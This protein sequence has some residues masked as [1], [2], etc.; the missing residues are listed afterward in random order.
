VPVTFI[1][2]EFMP[3]V[4]NVVIPALPQS[5]HVMKLWAEACK[6]LGTLD[7]SGQKSEACY[8]NLGSLDMA[9]KWF[10]DLVGF[11][12]EEVLRKM[13]A[14]RDEMSMFIWKGPGASE[15]SKL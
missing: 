9:K 14:A 12:N 7:A 5:L 13:R 15:N 8:V 4:W 10:E 3:H 2:Y 11:S 1:E 6:R